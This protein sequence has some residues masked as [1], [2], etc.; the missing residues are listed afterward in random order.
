MRRGHDD[1]DFGNRAAMV[2]GALALAGVG[3]VLL[4]Q[5]GTIRR[6]LGM[7]RMSARRHPTPPAT[8]KEATKTPPRWGTSHW[9]IH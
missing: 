8:L 2:M 6:Y 3:V 9:P 4:T 5:L 7:R 1:H